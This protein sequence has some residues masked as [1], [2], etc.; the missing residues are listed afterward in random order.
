M[1]ELML[2]ILFI[3]IQ[4]EQNRT[5]FI[6]ENRNQPLQQQTLLTCLEVLKK[7]SDEQEAMSLLVAGT[8]N[9]MIYILPPD[10]TGSAYLCKIALKS[11]PV[12]L[13]ITG[14]FDTEW[15][16]NLFGRYL[17]KFRILHCELH[18]NSINAYYC[19]CMF[20]CCVCVPLLTKD[21]GGMSR[22]HDL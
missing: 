12:M 7:D 8:E 17:L 16:L 22:W 9:G 4:N 10:P 15:R 18:F 1:M 20:V 13:N 11:V 19:V 14:L 21:C 6:D 5:S 2:V 3:P